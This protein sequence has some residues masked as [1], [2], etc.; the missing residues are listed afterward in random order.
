MCFVAFSC[1]SIS[2]VY[3]KD[4]V[5]FVSKP[6]SAGKALLTENGYG[7]SKTI[8]VANFSP[9]LR[10]PIQLVYRSS[11]LQTGLFGYGWSS[12]QLESSA[13]PQRDGVLWTTPWGEKIRFYAKNKADKE[14]LKLLNEPTTGGAFFSPYSD[15]N[16]SCS[17][18]GDKFSESG[19]WMF[20]GKRGYTGWTF[21]YRKAKLAKIQSSSGDEL[22]FTYAQNGG[23][24]SISQ[25]GQ[26]FV[27][28]A[29]SG[30]LA[31][32]VKINGIEHRFQYAESS[33]SIAPQTENGKIVQIDKPRLTSV[34]T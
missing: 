22:A 26:P 16:A 1:F 2:S 4:Q 32:S 19:D 29:F 34:I 28:I 3:A 7:L 20:S 18:S 9:E 30:V 14:T 10:L 5:N 25:N 13:V 6:L 31:S 21:T 11:S 17:A 15:W 23:I 24:A 12:P 27:E 33:V 8:G